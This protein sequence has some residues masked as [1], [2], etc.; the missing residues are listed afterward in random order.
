MKLYITSCATLLVISSLETVESRLTSRK[1]NT[2][3]KLIKQVQE[4]TKDEEVV[5]SLA[6][7]DVG[8][9]GRVLQDDMSMMGPPE[10]LC[11]D[12]TCDNPIEGCD[13]FDGICKPKDAAVPCIAIIDESDNFSDADIAAK[14]ANF[15]ELYPDRPFCLLQPL[16]SASSRLYI[17]PS[18]LSDSRTT[19][20]QVSRD[21]LGGASEIQPSPSDWF[22]ICG[23]GVYE[24]SDIDFIG[25]FLDTSGSMTLNTVRASNDLFDTNVSNAGLAIREV[26]NTREDWITPFVTT[27]VPGNV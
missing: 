11:A 22:G 16:N 27:L 13:P 23:F 10:D 19:F 3:D 26:F 24:G 18:F 5:P 12:V 15:R 25:K 20:A 9:W 14:W 21:D 17:P 7:E 1:E 8:F 2:K 4:E 6:D